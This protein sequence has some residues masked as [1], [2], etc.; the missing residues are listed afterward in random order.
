MRKITTI[1]LSTLVGLSTATFAQSPAPTPAPSAQ[2]TTAATISHDVKPAKESAAKE[3]T[4]KKKSTHHKH[5][6]HETKTNK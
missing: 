3:N 4:S 1:L 2:G 5:L 6:T